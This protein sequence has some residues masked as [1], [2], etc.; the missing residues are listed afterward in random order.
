MFGIAQATKL[1]DQAEAAVKDDL[2]LLE[3]VRVARMPLTY[4][5]LYP[6][7]GYKLEDNRLVFQGDLASMAEVNEFVSRMKKHGF[8]EIRES[9]GGGSEQ[10]LMIKAMLFSQPE[11][12][13][14]SNEHLS[15]D[16]VPTLAGRAMRIIDRK[17]D[18]CVTAYNVKRSIFFPFC[19]G[20][21]NRVGELFRYSGWMEP[22]KVVDRTTRSVSIILQTVDGFDLQRTLT[23]V[24]GKP[25]LRVKS[26]LTNPGDK[27]RSARLRSHL[28]LDLGEL[29]SIK[30]TFTNLA[31][32]MIDQDLTEIIAGLR[33]GEYY[34]SQNT[35]LNSWNF[36]G[37][38]GLQLIQRFKNDQID[39]AQLYAYPEDLGELE[40]ELWGKRESTTLELELELRSVSR[41]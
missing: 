29:R 24:P 2:E 27:Q 15:V 31:G 6:R 10:M 41:F 12:V 21:E 18:Q 9:F 35:P 40:V 39:Y 3:R 28:E 16:V 11:V 8:N 14:I 23:L 13:T 32:Q 26:V 33:E 34:R 19:G 30:L 20:L 37:N 22:A 7:N 5:R 38:K 17:S 36:T 4:A 25:I 1:F